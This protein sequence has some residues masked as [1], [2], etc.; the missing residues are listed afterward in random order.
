MVVAEP[1]SV[2]LL[3][4]NKN[5][6]FGKEK[7]EKWLDAPCPSLEIIALAFIPGVP[8][9]QTEQEVLSLRLMLHTEGSA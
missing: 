7:R 1:L 8:T 5:K 6:L 3:A 4:L 9:P 2:I